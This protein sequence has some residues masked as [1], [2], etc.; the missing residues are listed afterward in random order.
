MLALFATTSVDAIAESIA[1][2][3]IPF[4]PIPWVRPW[5]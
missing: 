2:R 1:I 4:C 3:E 5:M